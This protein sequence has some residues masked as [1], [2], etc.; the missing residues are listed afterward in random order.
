M[1]C[2]L[3]IAKIGDDFCKIKTDGFDGVIFTEKL[4]CK[5]SFAEANKYDLKIIVH[6]GELCLKDCL[7]L[8]PDG[9]AEGKLYT[10]MPEAVKAA[11]KRI[12]EL[13]PLIY[14]F[15]VPVPILGGLLWQEGFDAEYEEESGGDFRYDMPF[16]FDNSTEE[17]YIRRW[18]FARAAEAMFKTYILPLVSKE[19]EQGKKICF[20]LGSAGSSVE[21]IK[22]QIDPYMFLDNKLE[23]IYESKGETILSNGKYQKEEVLLVVP[24][25]SIMLHMPWGVTLSRFESPLTLALSEEEYYKLMLKRWNIKFRGI[26]E[27]RFSGM[28]RKELEKYKNILICDSCIPIDR[29]GLTGLKVNDK[30]L[31]RL[32]DKGN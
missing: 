17:T 21:L 1:E 2:R 6:I 10:V 16:I 31:L 9:V 12:K 14:G 5:E 25:Y 23:V 32:L 8:G 18:Y 4:V 24:K 30:E 3:K 19:A 28:K 29:S 15:V 13:M 27:I 11:A 20:Y 22:R 7:Y 26:D